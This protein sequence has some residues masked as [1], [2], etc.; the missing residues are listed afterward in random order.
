MSIPIPAGAY[1]PGT[2]FRWRQ[3]SNSGS[4]FDCWA[5]D[6]FCVQ[7]PVPK[8]PGPPPFLISNPN[9]ATAIAI[10]WADSDRSSYYVI[11][12][13]Q[14][15]QPWAALAT[16]PARTPY[17]TDTNALPSTAYS[18]R[19]KAGNAGGESTYSAVT[20]SLTW[21]QLEDWVYQ[22][23]GSIDAL[24]SDE[25]GKPGPDGIVRALR[26]AFNLAADTPA[27]V[28]EAG[29]SSG[30]P[31]IWLDVPRNRLCVEFVRRKASTNPGVDYTVQFCD[32]LPAWQE[33]GTQVTITPIDAIWERVRWEGSRSRD[34]ANNRFCQV[35][36]TLR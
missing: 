30:F 6:D 12:R 2:Q 26:Y 21:S 9:S 11:E 25:L 15:N 31:A 22:N 28:L 13:K 32:A 18:Y 16:I 29:G 5:L 27:S 24:T 8:P 14:A 19:I 1:S 35:R 10:F 36:V 34:T 7:P 20:T 23:Y 17:Y 3:L 4:R 33:S